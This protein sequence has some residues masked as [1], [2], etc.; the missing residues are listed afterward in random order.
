MLYSNT[1]ILIYTYFQ[2]LRI[3]FVLYFLITMFVIWGIRTF[4]A[5]WL[6]KADL[7]TSSWLQ[8]VGFSL[9]NPAG[10]WNYKSQGT[11]RGINSD[12]LD[13]GARMFP[14]MTSCKGSMIFKWKQKRE[15]WPYRNKLQGDAGVSSHTGEDVGPVYKTSMESKA[16]KWQ[17]ILGSC[18]ITLLK[19]YSNK[20]RRQAV[21]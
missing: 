21:S 8:S 19:G 15:M 14:D 18:V 17:L 13:A 9:I 5:D 2:A 4:P 3:V 7:D 1:F 11:S 6:R 10:M 16:F 12:Q 20:K